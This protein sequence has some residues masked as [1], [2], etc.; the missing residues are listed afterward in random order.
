MPP[1]FR[2]HSTG[3]KYRCEPELHLFAGPK[4]GGVNPV[5]CTQGPSCQG[6]PNPDQKKLHCILANLH[7]LCLEMKL[8]MLKNDKQFA[9]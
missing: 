3:V 9:K 7:I 1:R 6:G 2:P 4:H 5:H 8:H